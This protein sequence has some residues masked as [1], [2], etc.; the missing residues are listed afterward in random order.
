ME[1]SWLE[2]IYSDGSKFFLSNQTPKRGE[3]FTITIRCYEDSPVEA[4]YLA[5]KI[6]G[7]LRMGRM[8]KGATKL[9]LVYYY[10]NVKCWE[11]VFSYQFYICTNEKIYYYNQKGIT[12]FECQ[13]TYNFKIP[14]DYDSPKW[15]RKSV[16]Y[17]IFPD[18]F[19][20]GN[21]DISV[22]DEEYR[23]DGYYT[24]EIKQWDLP[25]ETYEN[26]H[27]LDFYGG[28]IEGIIKKIPYLKK[29]GVNAIYINPI[30]SAA[31]VHRYDCIDYFHVDSHLGG[32]QMFSKLV[33]I[34]HENDMRIIVDISINHTS[35]SHKWFNKTG[36]FYDLKDGAYYN[37]DVAERQYY[38]FSDKNNE[39][40]YYDNNKNMPV[41]NYFSFGLREIIYEG[42]NSV[43]KKWLKQPYNIDGWRFDCGDIVACNNVSNIQHKIWNDIR[44]AVKSVDTEK[45]IMAEHWTDAS[46]FLQGKEWDASMNYFGFTRPIRKLLGDSDYYHLDEEASGLM[47]NKIFTGEDFVNQYCEYTSKLP[48]V[49]QQNMFNLLDSHDLPRLHTIDKICRQDYV[50]TLVVMFSII[51]TPSIYYGDEL[52]IEGFGKFIWES[53]R[54]PMP[55]KRENE[56]TELFKIY[57]KLTEIKTSKVALSE[58][59]MKVIYCKKNVFAFARIADKQIIITVCSFDDEISEVKFSI[60][61]FGK[62]D[63]KVHKDL[64]GNELNY[65]CMDGIVSMMLK[66][67]SVYL[68]ESE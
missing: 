46:D 48:F 36:E 58:G 38:Y 54:F 15:V 25:P 35:S 40:F 67:H 3:E 37:K 13:D 31:S 19:C 27:C 8:K 32:N 24:K 55:W 1:E 56:Q 14:I 65:M 43:V 30:F 50:S 39:Y 45:Y 34:L 28:D 57:S 9:G 29:L 42:E 47:S 7:H 23:I 16:F 53:C 61:Q 63:I 18:R 41:L 5:A 66:P 49:I 17:Q 59:G 44:K 10:S 60:K 68:I 20:N 4:V 52:E 64:L 21:S 51:G 33:K 2:S 62:M 12:T 22:K 26:A 6:N 11:K